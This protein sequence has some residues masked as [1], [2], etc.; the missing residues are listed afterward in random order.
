M[1]VWFSPYWLGRCHI[2][3]PLCSVVY[4]TCL[5]NLTQSNSI[6]SRK[7]YCWVK[8][9]ANGRDALTVTG[10]QTNSKETVFVSGWHLNAQCKSLSSILQWAATLKN[11]RG[12]GNL[13]KFEK[14]L[15]KET[16]PPWPIYL[17]AT[18][19]GVSLFQDKVVRPEFE[20]QLLSSLVSK[21]N[22]CTHSYLE[23]KTQ[24]H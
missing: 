24:I 19:L 14:N 15:V 17:P 1:L 22:G 23:L 8:I 9:P 16:A 11:L 18:S 12:S 5:L 4:L 6:C 3:C 13:F 10:P 2:S 7:C 20:M 21:C